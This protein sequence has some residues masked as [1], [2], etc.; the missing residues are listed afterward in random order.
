[1]RHAILSLAASLALLAC[2]AA[3]DDPGAPGAPVPAGAYT[4]DKSHASL[5][6]RVD[7]LGFS[8]YTGQFKRF[9]AHLQFDPADPARS[10]VTVTIDPASLDLTGAPDGFLATLLGE[11]W[12]GAGQYPAMT[13]RSRQIEALQA[14]RLRI[15]GEL[16]FRGVA[17]PVTLDAT[18][19]GG[20]AGHP[21][22]PNARIGF[23]ARGTLQRSKFGMTIGVP[24][25][26]STMGVGDEVEF[27]IETEFTGPPLATSR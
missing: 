27:L 14:G 6:F 10:E 9:D 1:M 2:T 3:A 22:D 7:H 19:N 5:V 16:E 26:G 17:Q 13:F 4:L 15:H 21:L 20:Y 18:Y 12:L 24:P 25:P 23:S 11:E 8:K